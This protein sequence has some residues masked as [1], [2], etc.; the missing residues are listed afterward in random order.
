MARRA[1]KKPPAKHAAKPKARAA[2]KAAPRRKAARPAVHVAAPPAS[3]LP[4]GAPVPRQPAWRAGLLAEMSRGL[5]RVDATLGRAEPAPKSRGG[6]AGP[7][8]LRASV[9]SALEQLAEQIKTRRDG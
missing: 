2:H 3:A 4:A 9:R 7:R 6:K 1:S 8:E 5:E